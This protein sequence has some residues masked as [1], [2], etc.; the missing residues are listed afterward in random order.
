MKKTFEGWVFNRIEII[1]N[2]KYQHIGCEGEKKDFGAFLVH[3]VPRIGMRRKVKFTI[4]ALEK[5][6][7]MKVR[8]RKN[9]L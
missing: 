3:F 8:K 2:K 9:K 1:G 7:I 4:E 6:K 5:P